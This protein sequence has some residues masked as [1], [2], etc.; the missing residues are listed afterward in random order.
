M[1][2]FAWIS[3][4][5][6]LSLST[7]LRAESFIV[8]DIEVVGIKKIAI[9]TVFSYLPINVGESLDVERTP[10]LIRELYSTGFFDDIELLRRDN[11]LI[12]KVVE[13]PSIAEVNFEGNNDI[14]D[15]ALEQAME[16]VGMAK[17]RI[18]D[19]NKLEKLELDDVVGAVPVHLG[20]G[21]WGTL[22]VALFGDPESW[23][24]GLGRWEQLV[25]Q[26]TGVGATFAWAFGVGFT[27]LW[28]Y[29]RR[30]PLRIDPEGE[31]IGLNVAEHGASTEILDLLTDMDRQ[32]SANDFSQPVNVEP[33]TEVGQIA[34]Q[35]NH[36][37]ADITT[38]QRRR[39]AVTESL[40]ERTESLKLLRRIAASANRARTV[41]E[42]MQICL[43]DIC[44]FIGWPVGHFYIIDDESGELVSTKVWHLDDPE[45][46]KLFREVTE[47]HRLKVGPGL[48][49]H[50]Y[51][52]GKPTWIVD[53]TQ[54]PTFRRAKFAKD[55]GVKAGFA[56]PV[57]VGNDVVAVLEYLFQPGG[58]LPPPPFPQL[59][60][61][62]TQDNLVCG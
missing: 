32:R 42:A 13:R 34:Q 20:A 60:V 7:A 5:V 4:L 45:R 18:F 25:V 31:R 54:D 37:L 47:R 27:L 51:A 8:E 43:E 38:E 15:E 29:N 56:F 57:L 16:G 14:E 6:L 11:V 30:Y 28:L 44:T 55:I 22:A 3:A 53:V 46:F 41:D 39:E 24:T 40:R 21:I 49:G 12:I 62:P 9:G 59:G 1:R 17:G 52:T 26:A 61:D 19:K 10:E 23:G 50:T 36:V 33:N 2:I 48:S 35:Y 58:A